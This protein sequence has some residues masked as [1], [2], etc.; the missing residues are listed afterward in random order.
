M[1]STLSFA[2]S[3]F[4]FL[5]FEDKKCAWAWYE[6][7]ILSQIT[8]FMSTMEKRIAN[9][10]ME[11]L[12]LAACVS[13]TL[14]TLFFHFFFFRCSSSFYTFHH[15]HWKLPSGSFP[16]SGSNNKK[17]LSS[18]FARIAPLYGSGTAAMVWERARARVRRRH[19]TF[20]PH[21]ISKPSTRWCSWPGLI[22][23]KLNIIVGER[24]TESI[25]FRL[26][27]FAKLHESIR[28]N[29]S[30]RQFRILFTDTHL[31][32]AAT[33]AVSF[34]SSFGCP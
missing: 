18:F 6:I 23:T 12:H 30:N 2:K 15:T 20:A 16:L 7:F 1:L 29:T 28:W 9:E 25:L 4:F 21:G 19:V 31:I 34:A 8:N 32:F 10:K 24:C 3:I 13:V 27:L 33:S 22:T 26:W 17:H 11:S 14:P 5:V